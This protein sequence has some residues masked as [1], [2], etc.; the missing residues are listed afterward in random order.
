MDEASGT[1]E[2]R[3]VMALA[4]DLRISSDIDPRE[5]LSLRTTTPLESNDEL[6]DEEGGAGEE[7]GETSN[8]GRGVGGSESL[9]GRCAR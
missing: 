5:L 9:L 2:N 8:R 4:E 3:R 1:D 6:D 7:G